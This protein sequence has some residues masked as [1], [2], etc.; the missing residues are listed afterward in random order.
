MPTCRQQG[1]VCTIGSDRR[2]VATAGEELRRK[3]VEWKACL[4]SK[5][6][7]LNARKNKVFLSAWPRG[8]CSK[9]IAAKMLHCTS[10]AG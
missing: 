10:C 4:L 8:V 9:V 5:G 1:C 6:I 2:H 3:L 7:K